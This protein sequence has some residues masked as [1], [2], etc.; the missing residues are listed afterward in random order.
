MR[1]LKKSVTADRESTGDGAVGMFF[2]FA[3]SGFG[4]GYVPVAQ[5]TF[6]S[7]WGP[8]LSFLVPGQSLFILWC[9]LPA[10]FLAGVWVSARSERWWGH[11]PGRT[12]I[13]EAVGVIAATAFLPQ[14]TAVVWTGFFLFRAADILKPFPVGRCERLPGGWGVMADDLAAGIM[15]NIAL[16]IIGLFVPGM[17]G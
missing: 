7:L 5:G 9:A 14:T 10:L 1:I 17:M 3:A 8:L 16:R 12:V 13:D 4:I 2:R 11:D 6:G 15:V